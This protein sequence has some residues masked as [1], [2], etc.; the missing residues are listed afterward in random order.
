MILVCIECPSRDIVT[1]VT[2]LGLD[3]GYLL[4]EIAMAVVVCQNYACT[5]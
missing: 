3:Y 2:V 4:Y 5:I 1:G